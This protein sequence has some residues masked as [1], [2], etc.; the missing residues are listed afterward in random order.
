MFVP[1][2]IVYQPPPT[3]KPTPTTT[4]AGYTPP[5]VP[6]HI[7]PP[8][9]GYAI[10][11]NSRLIQLGFKRELNY[12]FVAK[13]SYAVSQIIAFVPQ[14]VSYGLE[15]ELPQV[16]M[17]KLAPYDGTVDY[18]AT[19]A[20]MYIPE[21]LVDKLASL[22][23]NPLSALFT[24]PNPPI[25]KMMSLVDP[26]IPLIPGQDYQNPRPG[27][28]NPGS[29]GGPGDDNDGERDGHK[30]NGGGD[31]S[32]NTS[33]VKASAVG[34]GLGVVGGA[35]LYGA[36]MFFVARRYRR[37][38]RMHRRTSSLTSGMDDDRSSGAASP[39]DGLMAGGYRD[40]HGSGGGGSA[41][42]A[43]ISAPVMSENSLGW[44]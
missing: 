5:P 15:I 18:R 38:R 1:T 7:A 11:A 19:L 41:R 6:G 2:E 36:A 16:Y 44:N 23:A 43:M 32:G 26:T 42:T 13:N 12:D 4:E 39:S 37:K 27:G 31:G 14:G 35:A 40:S 30:G 25:A 10:P 33:G 34:I 24:H 9:G 3:H 29:P 28:Q 17:H 20:M 8:D 21:D 22:L